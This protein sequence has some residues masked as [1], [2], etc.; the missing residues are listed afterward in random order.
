[1]HMP[2]FW[3]HNHISTVQAEA[4]P[5]R[6]VPCKPPQVPSHHLPCVFHTLK[7]KR[8]KQNKLCTEVCMVYPNNCCR[9]EKQEHIDNERP[10]WTAAK[11]HKHNRGAKRG[12]VLI[13]TLERVVYQACSITDSGKCRQRSQRVN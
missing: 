9:Q 13:I 8:D 5:I 3:S 11:L 12:F 10:T 6:P 2:S 1:M 7:G 4:K